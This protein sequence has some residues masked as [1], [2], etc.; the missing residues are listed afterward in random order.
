[1]FVCTGH[2]SGSGESTDEETNSLEEFTLPWRDQVLLHTTTL[3][4]VPYFLRKDS[5]TQS[6]YTMSMPKC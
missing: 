5:T 4:H 1:M 6:V 2:D 3:R